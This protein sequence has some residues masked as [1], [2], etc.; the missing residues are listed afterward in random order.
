MNQL[1]QMVGALFILATQPLFSEILHQEFSPSLVK[2]NCLEWCVAETTPFDELVVSWNAARPQVG[3]FAITVSVKTKEWSEDLLYAVWGSDG[4]C[5]FMSTAA[6]LQV[7][8]N[9]DTVELLAGTKARG[10]CVKVEA[11]N[12]AKFDDFWALHAA[13]VDLEAFKANSHKVSKWQ[14]A[15][16][17]YVPVPGRS[18]VALCH[19]RHMDLCSPTS[20][21]SVVSFL[22]SCEIP[23]VEFAENVWDCSF[24]IYGNWIFNMAESAAIL[25][26]TW[27]CYAGRLDTFEPIFANLERAVPSVVSVRGPLR[28]AIFPYQK[29]H[30]IAVIGYDAKKD[31]ILCMDPAYPSDA[32]SLVS[33]DREDFLQAWSRR[34]QIAYIFEKR[35]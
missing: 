18:Q 32:E 17:A 16:S 13:F 26:K 27:R 4:Q 29:G 31:R 24:D 1:I 6:S 20:T 2:D 11:K 15:K 35:E 28:G 34:G 12:G 22:A 5:T 23:T 3:E 25:N 7:R 10:F 9:E 8:T 30:L 14:S 21:S 19:A 33:Y